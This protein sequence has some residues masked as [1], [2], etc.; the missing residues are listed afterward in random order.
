MT[1]SDNH[2]E[3]TPLTAPAPNAETT[4]RR[5][6]FKGTVAPLVGALVVLALAACSMNNNP[7][8]VTE[9]TDT[10]GSYQEWFGMSSHRRLHHPHEIK[11]YLMCTRILASSDRN[12]DN[13]L[14][15]DEFKDFSNRLADESLGVS[16]GNSLLPKELKGIFVDYAARTEG[17]S[18][19]IIDIYG[20]RNGERD[21]ITAH[22]E[23]LL[24]NLC[25]ETSY[26]LGDLLKEEAAMLSKSLTDG[27]MHETDHVCIDV[28]CVV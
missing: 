24:E 1:A 26:T 3:T 10:F 27:E 13:A 16:L 20:S 14:D 7:E 21:G 25:N 19:Q 28:L 9:W 15:I 11:K 12:Y 17:R 22:Q 6:Y 18:N 8:Q 23:E 4:S 2:E 5:S